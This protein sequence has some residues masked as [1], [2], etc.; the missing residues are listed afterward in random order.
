MQCNAA[1]GPIQVFESPT[2]HFRMR[3]EFDIWHSDHRATYVMMD[4]GTRVEVKHFPMACRLISEKL[5]PRLHA[6]L[7]EEEV[8]RRGLFQV[9]FQ[10]TK[11]GEAM[12]S[13]RYKTP[14]ARGI[15]KCDLQSKLTDDW[16]AAGR[17]LRDALDGAHVVGFRRGEHRAVGRDW[18]QEHLTVAGATAQL[19]YRQ[20]AGFFSQPN[21]AVAEQMLAWARAVGRADSA[22]VGEDGPPRDDDLLELYCGNGTFAIALA[23]CFR[24]VLATELVKGLVDC[25]IQNAKDN[26]C[27]NVSLARVS[28]EELAQALNGTRTFERMKHVDLTKYNFQTVLVDPPRAGLGPEVA[29]FLSRY[30]RIVYV[31]CNP[32]T[33]RQ[34]MDILRESHD[35]QRMAVFDQFPYTHHAEMGVL[36]VQ[37][38]GL[39]GHG[40]YGTQQLSS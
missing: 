4:A 35:I 19:H 26:D 34:D 9:L 40:K 30:K 22:I 16:E 21:A 31:S 5:M 20:L 29:E 36:L 24:R 12:V 17:R 14:F 39:E 32:K 8:L 23:P 27:E 25:A 1:W 11:S 38:S 37:R 6:V 33:L 28:A 7:Q 15:P 18:I 10:A 13:L 3:V 2:E